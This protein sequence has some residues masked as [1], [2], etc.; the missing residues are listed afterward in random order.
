MQ[1]LGQPA[2][3]LPVDWRSEMD[4]PGGAFL[5]AGSTA[6]RPSAIGTVNN[7]ANLV[8]LSLKN[9]FETSAFARF[10]GRKTGQIAKRCQHIEQVDIAFETLASLDAWPS[11]DKRDAPRMLV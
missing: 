11:D 5:Q 3:R 10:G 6:S 9:R 7:I 8:L 2:I 4:H 1:V